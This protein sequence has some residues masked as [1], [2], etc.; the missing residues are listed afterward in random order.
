M[1][2]S[3]TTPHISQSITL[4]NAQPLK[5]TMG[6]DTQTLDEV[7]VTALGIKREQ[8]A[9]S[10]NVQQVKGE[11]LTAVKDAN[12][13]NSLAGKVAGVQ[14]SSGA[15]GAGGTTRVVMRGAKSIEGD[16]NALYVVDGIPLFN[17]NMGNTDSGIMGEVKAISDWNTVKTMDKAEAEKAGLFEVI[18]KEV[19]DAYMAE[20]KKQVIHMDAIQAEGKNL[21]I[22]YTPL[23][24]T[25]NIPVRRILRELGFNQ[26]YVVK[27]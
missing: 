10:Y 4:A 21:K 7:V 9:L 18:G 1:F 22:V 11:A 6:E 20:L 13:I 24:G 12:F 14:I 8:K 16:N 23:H 2:F 3:H 26:V 5:V 15:T 25:G 19:D 17:T 27:E